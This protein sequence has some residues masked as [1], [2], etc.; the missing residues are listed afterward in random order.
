[1]KKIIYLLLISTIIFSCEEK[2][3]REV[4]FARKNLNR[5]LTKLFEKEETSSEYRNSR[6]ILFDIKWQKKK[7]LEYKQLL[8]AKG[9][10]HRY[11]PEV[12]KNLDELLDKYT[13]IFAERDKPK[14]YTCNICGRKFVGRGYEERSTGLWVLVQEP[15]Q[16]FICSKTCGA[17]HTE[18]QVKRYGF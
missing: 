14:R 4:E 9:Y 8:E 13:K 10:S 15:Y 6:K 12:I 18:R 2:L 3:P 11:N 16:S 7:V 17:I 5:S 1:M